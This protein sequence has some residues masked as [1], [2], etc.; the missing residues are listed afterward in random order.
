MRRAGHLAR[1]FFDSVRARPP[2]TGDRTFVHL[3]LTPDELAVWET[4]GRADQAESITTARHVARALGPDADQRWVAAALLHDVGKVDA[5]LG[6]VRRAGATVVAALVSH[7]RARQW[8]NKI[9]RYVSHDERGEEKLRA[10]GARPETAA[11]AGAHHRRDRFA[12]TGI[13]AEIC[14]LLAEADGESAPG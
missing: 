11:W 13:P 7:G 4:L 5:G 2:D 10:A 9:G 3:T 14:E 1:R 6:P 8:S 12:T